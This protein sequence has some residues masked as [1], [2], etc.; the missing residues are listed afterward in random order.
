[1]RVQRDLATLQARVRHGFGRP[2][3]L[4]Q[5]LTH[6]SA[7]SGSGE[8]RA[9]YERLEFLGDRVLGLVIAAELVSAFPQADEGE[10]SRRLSDLVRKETCAA[11][12][13]EWGLGPNLRLGAGEAQTGGRRKATILAD[14]C[15]AVIGAAFL[16]GGFAAARAVVLSGWSARL[17]QSPGDRRD[18]KTALQERVQAE[19]FTP[20]AYREVSRSGPDHALVFVVVATVTGL[21]SARGEGRSKREAEQAAARAFLDGRIEPAGEENDG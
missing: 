14:A 5:A 18:A 9:S 10:L 6:V 2:E 7:A 17:T 21:G 11:V 12:A 20:P 19:G 13:G 16:D 1:M 3:L 8:R 4:D 15:E